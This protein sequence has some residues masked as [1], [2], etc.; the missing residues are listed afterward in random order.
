[1]HRHLFSAK[2]DEL[3][4]VARKEMIADS[5]AAEP[6]A[7][8]AGKPVRRQSALAG[9]GVFQDVSTLCKHYGTKLRHLNLTSTLYKKINRDA[10]LF[11]TA[12]GRAKHGGS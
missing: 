6:T 10:H 1:L 12:P 7:K 3:A 9:M 8:A 2:A 5:E 4:E 11:L